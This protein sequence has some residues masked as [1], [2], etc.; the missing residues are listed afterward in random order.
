[1]RG[2]ERAGDRSWWVLPL[3]WTVVP[4]VTALMFVK[5]PFAP[6]VAEEGKAMRLSQLFR[7]P[8]FLVAMLI[9]ICAGASELTMS[10]WASTFAEKG[11]EV[12]KVVGDLLGQL[13]GALQ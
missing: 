8:M 13:M 11:L 3:I 9:M 1:M 4:A 10:Q 2:S 12:S 6:I 5:A 7:Q